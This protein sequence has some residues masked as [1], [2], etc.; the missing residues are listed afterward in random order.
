MNTLSISRIACM[1]AA[2]FLL[3]CSKE[4]SN[5][6][7]EV[8]QAKQ[9]RKLSVPLADGRTHI[10]V[11][12]DDLSGS[13][14]KSQASF[15]NQVTQIVTPN[16]AYLKSTMLMDLSKLTDFSIV[17]SIEDRKLKISL[18]DSVIKMPG[19]PNGWTALWNSKP[20]VE[21]EAPT[22]LYTRQQNRL[23]IQLSKYVQTFGFELSPNLYDT[24]EFTAGF[25][26]SRENTPVASLTQAATTPAGAKLFA[27]SSKRPFNVIELAFN[28][29]QQNGNHPYGFAIANIRYILCKDVED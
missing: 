23:T 10:E 18:T 25:Y 20:F 5:S 29:D 27:V 15:L 3:A 21:Q 9:T 8:A 16:E 7:A 6:K 2:L 4:E 17:N 24:Y 19:F 12:G 14:R 11:K 1:S 26:D 13:L 28:G 22:V